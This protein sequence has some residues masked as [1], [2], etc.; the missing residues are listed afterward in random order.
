MRGLRGVSRLVLAPSLHP[1]SAGRPA[2]ST[3]GKVL[4][5]LVMLAVVP[6]IWLY[7]KVYELNS[8]WGEEI[9]R[10]SKQVDDL[11]GQVAKKQAELDDAL[12]AVSREKSQRDDELTVL[13][14]RV[15]EIEVLETGS[16]EAAERARLQIAL[17]EAAAKDATA[18]VAGRVKELNDTQKAKDE[19]EAL[20]K[21]LQNSV[22]QRMDNLATLRQEFLRLVEENRQ[23]LE[24]L[25]GRKGETPSAARTGRV[26]PVSFRP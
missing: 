17:L 6:W 9:Q 1:A 12:L 10:L 8:S 15:S 3:A 14:T 19:A 13:T 23:M 2:M 5:V 18:T 21:S 24:R 26:R 16:R 25:R 7:A 20:V 4:V 22:Q 11:G